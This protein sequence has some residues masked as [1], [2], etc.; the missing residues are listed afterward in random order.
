M[1]KIALYLLLLCFLTVQSCRRKVTAQLIPQDATFVA[2]IQLR[3][4]VQKAEVKH[5]SLLQTVRQY[6]SQLIAADDRDKLDAVLDDPTLL[7]FD[8]DEPGFVFQTPDHSTG[9]CLTVKDEDRVDA[10]FDFLAKQQLC[11]KVTKKDG[12]KW[13][14]LLGEIPLAYNGDVLLVSLPITAFTGVENQKKWIQQ[15][16]DN[17][18]DKGFFES[19]D[20]D[21]SF[22]ENPDFE[23][24][25]LSSALP[26]STSRQLSELLPKGLHVG[27]VKLQA[28]LTFDKGVMRFQSQLTGRTKEAQQLLDKWDGNLRPITDEFLQSPIAGCSVFAALNS[29]GD[30]LLDLLKKSADVKQGLFMLERGIDIEA[31]LCSVDG[32]MAMV[33]Q[34]WPTSTD[35][36]KDDFLFMAHVDNDQW[37]SEVDAWKQSAREF[38]INLTPASEKNLYVLEADGFDMVWGVNDHQLLLASRQAYN[39]RAFNQPNAALQALENE[40]TSSKLFA[41]VDFQQLADQPELD[42]FSSL[43]FRSDGFSKQILQ[44]RTRD[45]KS[46]LL[47]LLLQEMEHHL[48]N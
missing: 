13:T 23:V 45:E 46:N 8:F 26:L 14:S 44:L 15:I 20:F 31:M 42:Y 34:H 1:K 29:K 25:A 18:Q 27:D 32:D 19:D 47:S 24:C 6:A 41:Y 2:T 43:V 48:K 11:S 21:K 3:Q 36:V 22:S 38:G 28:A 30:W 35:V 39:Q 5:S 4:L 37:L 16:F 33:L 17:Q 7:G 12:L 40:I 9:L 10:F